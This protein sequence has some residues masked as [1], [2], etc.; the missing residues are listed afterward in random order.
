[1][2]YSTKEIER[3]F[4]ALGLPSSRRTIH[5]YI[6]S[7]ELPVEARFE[8]KQGG[9]YYVAKK[10]DVEALVEKQIPIFEELQ[11]HQPELLEMAKNYKEVI[12]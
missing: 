7:G 9:I 8:G 6:T 4:K 11:K 3:I 12:K 10:E 2:Y 1:M 5:R